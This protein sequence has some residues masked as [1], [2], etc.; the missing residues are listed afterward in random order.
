MN[1]GLLLGRGGRILEKERGREGSCDG[2]KEK[3]FTTEKYNVLHSTVCMSK[4][5]H[6][7]H[8]AEA[9]RHEK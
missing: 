2:V 8:L 5:Q 1:R 4:Y 9:L 6:Y 7:R 3:L